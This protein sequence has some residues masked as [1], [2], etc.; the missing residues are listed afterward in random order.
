M[1]SADKVEI[2]P[3]TTGEIL[4]DAWRLYLSNVPLLLALSGLFTV[5]L[6]TT[7]LLLLTLPRP[8]NLVLQFVLPVLTALALPITGLASGACQAAFLRL[9]EGE[10]AGLKSCWGAALRQGLDHAAARALLVLVTSPALLLVVAPAVVLWVIGLGV[11]PVLARGEGRL[12]QALGTSAREIQRQPVKSL[13]VFLVRPV[14]LLFAVFNLHMFLWGGLWVAE[15]L[16]GLDVA[17]LRVS[18]SLFNPVYDAGLVLAAWILLVPYAEAVNYLLHIDAE[19][20]FQGLDLE[21]RVQRLFPSIHRA[22]TGMI[23]A[24]VA[25]G[26]TWTGAARAVDH[27]AEVQK[28]RKDLAGIQ[29]EVAAAN[30]YPGG[31]RWSRRLSRIA[32]ELD[33]GGT[34][35]Q[36]RYR[37]FRQGIQG[38]ARLPKEEALNTLTELDR[39]LALVEASLPPAESPQQAGSSPPLTTDD[40]K[41]LLPPGSEEANK[42]PGAAPKPS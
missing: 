32:E 23:L 38:F 33:P 42:N 36:G 26:L 39:K 13:V 27:R 30:P 29:R 3:R 7:L 41:K 21:Y 10:A 15:N 19:A 5:P 1:A 8:E 28:A 12:L 9:A 24:A 18:L 40:I 14:L 37:W 20:R 11:H 6:A 35:K 31:A 34:V 17:F 2:R 25:L 22:Q 16:A 4:D